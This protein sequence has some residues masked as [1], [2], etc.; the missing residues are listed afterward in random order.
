LII[1]PSPALSLEVQAI[2]SSALLANIFL[3]AVMLVVVPLLVF[4]QS[5]KIALAG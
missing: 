5:G 2:A 1:V 3:L 4:S